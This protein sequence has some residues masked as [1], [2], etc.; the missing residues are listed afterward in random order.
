MKTLHDGTKVTNSTPTK[1]V[2]GKRYLLTDEEI[3]ARTV[4]IEANKIPSN[5]Q[6]LSQVA[7][8]YEY[9]NTFTAEGFEFKITIESKTDLIGLYAAA[10][11]GELFYQNDQGQLV[12]GT[13]FTHNNGVDTISVQT[14]KN[15]GLAVLRHVQKVRV[16]K[17]KLKAGIQSGAIPTDVQKAWEALWNA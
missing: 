7:N 12:A 6:K 15:I 5:L 9:T 2:N 8:N 1:L 10:M 13:I 16:I 11:D 3:N 14:A 17:G 4:E